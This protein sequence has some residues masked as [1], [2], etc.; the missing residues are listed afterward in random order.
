MIVAVTS[1]I[2]VDFHIVS[3]DN[4]NFVIDKLWRQIDYFWCLLK[5][6]LEFNLTIF[7]KQKNCEQR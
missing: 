5:D 2:S 4:L 7:L 6:Y 3:V 1:S